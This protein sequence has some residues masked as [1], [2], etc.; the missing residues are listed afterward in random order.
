LVIV[1]ATRFITDIALGRRVIFIASNFNNL[2]TLFTSQ[3]YLNATIYKTDITSG[4]V[5]VI[6]FLTHITSP[7]LHIT[8]LIVCTLEIAAIMSTVTVPVV[9]IYTD[10]EQIFKLKSNE[11][12]ENRLKTDKNE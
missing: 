9:A 11:T 7:S 12:K 2:A 5:P 3:L 6:P 8:L 1:E 10:T 4:F